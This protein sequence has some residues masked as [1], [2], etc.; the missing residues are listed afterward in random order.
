MAI[1]IVDAASTDEDEEIQEV[2]ARLAFYSN[3]T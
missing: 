1:G 3:Q 2:I